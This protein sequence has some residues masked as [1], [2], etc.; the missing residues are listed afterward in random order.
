MRF[1]IGFLVL[2]PLCFFAEM[3]LESSQRGCPQAQ[4]NL[5]AMYAE[6]EGVAQNNVFSLLPCGGMILRILLE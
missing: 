5:E 1:P 6:S 4:F 2:I 3:V